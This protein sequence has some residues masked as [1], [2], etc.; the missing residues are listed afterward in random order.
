M[1]KGE[2]EFNLKGM[3]GVYKLEIKES[4]A[5]LKQLLRE[6]KNASGKERIQL[7]YLLKTQ[8]AKTVQAA[9]S[10]LGRNRVTVQEWMGHYRQGGL[11]K[12]LSKGRS[13]GRPRVIPVWAEQALSKRLQQSEGFNSYGEICQWLQ[14][15]LGIC[16]TY[17]T[18][19]KLV[20]GRL[21]AS[22]KVARPQSALQSQSQKEAYKKTLPTISP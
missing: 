14:S 8:Q 18:V 16:A 10:M 13:T 20:H 21:K 5:E 1:Y 9:A 19:H 2:V 12:L 11:E 4:E 3:A 6:Q 22:P 17:A 15:Q 7:L